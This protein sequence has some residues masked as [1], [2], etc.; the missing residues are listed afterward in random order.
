MRVPRAR[1]AEIVADA[2]ENEYLAGLAGKGQP[3]RALIHERRTGLVTM[4]TSRTD[5]QLSTGRIVR[6]LTSTP[7]ARIECTHTHPGAYETLS[8]VDLVTTCLPGIAWVTSVNELGAWMRA[9]PDPERPRSGRGE[10]AWRRDAYRHLLLAREAELSGIGR[11]RHSPAARS[12]IESCL[13]AGTRGAGIGIET[14]TPGHDETTIAMVEGW[15]RN[16]IGRG[17]LGPFASRSEEAWLALK[18]LEVEKEPTARARAHLR[19]L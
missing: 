16:A 8:Y 10:R 18:T 6:W 15:I 19:Q 3:E 9:T 13:R 5:R 2:R 4:R 14:S 17:E 12:W 1:L 11:D 7:F